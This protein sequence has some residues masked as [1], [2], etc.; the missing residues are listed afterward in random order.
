MPNHHNQKNPDSESTAAAV[1]NKSIF[2]KNADAAFDEF[3][4]KYLNQKNGTFTLFENQKSAQ[5]PKTS[6]Q[7]QQTSSTKKTVIEKSSSVTKINIQTSRSSSGHLAPKHFNNSDQLNISI[8]TNLPIEI[9]SCGCT[10]N[11]LHNDL[12]ARYQKAAPSASKSVPVA[13]K[14]PNT[15]SH[16][17]KSLPASSTL[18]KNQQTIDQLL[19]RLV[20]ATLKNK[21]K[22]TTSKSN[23]PPQKSVASQKQVKQDSSNIQQKASPLTNTINKKPLATPIKN[24]PSK[25]KQIE[26][27]PHNLDEFLDQLIKEVRKEPQKPATIN[28]VPTKR[29]VSLDSKEKKL[30]VNSLEVVSQKKVIN[31][32]KPKSEK[33]PESKPQQRIQKSQSLVTK[34][35]KPVEKIPVLHVQHKQ[36]L[37]KQKEEK[38]VPIPIEISKK[39]IIKNQESDMT[40]VL[41]I[42]DADQSHNSL[43]STKSAT[44]ITPPTTPSSPRFNEPSDSKLLFDVTKL[45]DIDQASEN[46]PSKSPEKKEETSANNQKDD[47]VI[48]NNL[49]KNEFFH[50]SSPFVY[51]DSNN[52][53]DEEFLKETDNLD[54]CFKELESKDN[55]EEP[56]DDATAPQSPLEQTDET[57]DSVKD[58][59]TFPVSIVI[60]PSSS[61][62][63]LPVISEG[64]EGNEHDDDEEEKDEITKVKPEEKQ[65]DESEKE[66]DASAKPVQK[67]GLRVHSFGT[68]KTTGLPIPKNNFFIEKGVFGDDAAFVAENDEA[69]AIGKRIIHF[70]NKLKFLN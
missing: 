9:K 62:Q 36:S 60:A 18:K 38:S 48:L 45:N 1:N 46:Q 3:C 23:N 16:L 24:E 44:P 53:N 49:F 41:I 50:R 65:K 17:S 61:N 26:K 10:Y 37:I 40:A 29:E 21:T 6:T 12:K 33:K 63:T 14:V 68:S 66:L 43:P 22:N 28:S 27:I 54:T 19:D 5:K 20:E 8:K 57:N 47:P 35:R 15:E 70:F 4:K 32:N 11:K 55:K 52:E 59:D 7:P 42:N 56:A 67:L 64:E 13:Q 69:D 51:D 25:T 58:N 2:T 39:E 34:N 30:V 31:T